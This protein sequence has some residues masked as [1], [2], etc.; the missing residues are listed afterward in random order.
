MTRK[1]DSSPMQDPIAPAAERGVAVETSTTTGSN[2]VVAVV[3]TVGVAVD[4]AVAGTWA[5]PVTTTNTV[6]TLQSTI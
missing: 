1:S 3:A 6:K 4:A 5:D 2:N